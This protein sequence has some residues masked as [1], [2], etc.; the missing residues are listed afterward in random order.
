MNRNQ[1][2]H[3]DNSRGFQTRRSER[4]RHPESDNNYRFDDYGSSARGGYGNEGHS[5]TWGNQGN[6]MAGSRNTS[7]QDV[8][9]TYSTSRNYGNMG[10]YGGAQGF[11]TSRGG[12][13]AQR[14][15][16]SGNTGYNYTS[17]MGNPGE[18]RDSDYSLGGHRVYGYQRD[19][20]SH[21]S[22][23]GND[24][25]NDRYRSGSTRG[26]QDS[27]SGNYDSNQKDY[28]YYGGMGSPDQARQ[29]NLNSPSR[30]INYGGGS[31]YGERDYGSDD[32]RGN[33]GSDRNSSSSGR[34]LY[35]SDTSRRFEG[36]RQGRYD[37]DE[38][39]Y[40][41]AGGN[42]SSSG[43]GWGSSGRSSSSN[44]GGSEGSYMGS[45][46]RRES[47]NDSGSY[48]GSGYSQNRAQSYG[49]SNR[50][51]AY[52]DRNFNSGFVSSDDS[53]SDSNYLASRNRGRTFDRDR[54]DDRER[55]RMGG[56]Y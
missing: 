54:G 35:G 17:G 2:E 15:Y 20:D 30:G 7:N 9:G 56:R 23:R 26:F 11:G 41:N 52:G 32:R 45:G 34:A 46:Y 51:G 24:R 22:D 27:N 47:Q 50:R 31:N 4:Y 29:S 44:Y 10:S 28:N 16:G 42:S 6:E 39:N 43:S 19:Y 53:H 38:D 8:Y 13:I 25:D 21:G 55:G 49:N 1:N 18:A 12:N 33:R 14:H 37:F 40:N 48:G 36:T 3:Q 5:G